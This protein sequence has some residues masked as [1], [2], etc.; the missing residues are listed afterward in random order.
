MDPLVWNKKMAPRC[1]VADGAAAALLPPPPTPPP[2]LGLRPLMEKREMC[3]LQ[4]VI[5][6]HDHEKTVVLMLTSAV[7]LHG[8]LGC[9]EVSPL[10]A[11]CV[12]KMAASL[13]ADSRS[14]TNCL[15]VITYLIVNCG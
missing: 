9:L 10:A 15:Y 11:G 5:L 3:L 2:P 4:M 12:T 13:S 8:G 7:L 1:L 6:L 14:V